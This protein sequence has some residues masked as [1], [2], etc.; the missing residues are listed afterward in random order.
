VGFDG[1]FGNGKLCGDLL[2]RIPSRNQL[3]DVDFPRREFVFPGMKGQFGSDFRRDSLLPG[4]HSAD[5]L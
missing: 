5:G 3:K 2:V 1:F 4:V